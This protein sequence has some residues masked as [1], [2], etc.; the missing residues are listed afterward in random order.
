MNKDFYPDV[1]KVI[2]GAILLLL[3]IGLIPDFNIKYKQI[4][5]LADITSGSLKEDKENNDTTELASGLSV[6]VIENDSVTEQKDTIIAV[7]KVTLPPEYQT[8]KGGIVPLED[9]SENK[10]ALNQ[11]YRS[12]TSLKTKA[13]QV[14]IGVMGDSFTEADIITADLRNKLQEI[15]G[16]TGVGFIPVASPAANY[17]KTI[18]HT[19]SGWTP[20]SMVYF[21]KADWNKFLISGFYYTPKEDA[22]VA[23][24]KK[25]SKKV[26][27]ASFLFINPKHT[28]ITVS[29]NNAAPQVY[30]PASSD[31]LQVLSFTSKDIESLSISVSKVDGFTA[32]GFYLN[33]ETGVYVDNFSVRGSSGIV[34]STVNEKLSNQLSQY[35]PYNMLILQYGLNVVSPDGK[36]YINYKKQMIATI[37]H[38]KECY[39]DTP[40]LFMSVGDKSVKEND[41]YVT[42]PG[43][44]PLVQIQR[45]I[46]Q[47]TSVIF[48]NTYQAMGGK[49]S[50][51]T[52]VNHTPPMAAKDYTHINYAGGSYI[53]GEFL[54]S[55]I[56]NK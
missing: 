4:N 55:F 17:R 19:F 32:F 5:L 44:E 18:E 16:G 20:Y 51:P 34:L 49:N 2:L 48:W 41:N 53:A 30:T 6:P 24:K 14:R 45:E 1:I 54:K 31:S 12:L 10:D 33:N 43:I 3:L 9:Y 13:A 52:F 28:Q 21:K 39:P 27:K 26:T 29:I 15:Y 56:N 22:F 8:E 11:I 50:M 38:I 23:L 37:N 35:F 42:H 40:V 7:K 25:D 47:E 36:R 46:A